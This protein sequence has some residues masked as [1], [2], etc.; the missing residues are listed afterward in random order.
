MSHHIE[1]HVSGSKSNRAGALGWRGAALL[2]LL[3]SGAAC[4][5]SAEVPD[6]AD[7][8]GQAASTGMYYGAYYNEYSSSSTVDPGVIAKSATYSNLIWLPL[9]GG[10]LTN[11]QLAPDRVTRCR[12]Q[13]AAVFNA[14]ASAGVSYIVEAGTG[15]WNSDY[16]ASVADAKARLRITRDNMPAGMAQRVAAVAI[17]DEPSLH[18]SY[19][20][21]RDKLSAFNRYVHELLPGAAAFLNFSTMEIARGLPALPDQTDWV[22][23]D[24]YSWTTGAVCRDINTVRTNLNKVKAYGGVKFVLIP[25]AHLATNRE[26]LSAEAVVGLLNDYKSLAL[27]EP[28]VVALM[29]YA[30]I[31]GGG[32]RGFANGAAD[33]NLIRT[34]V[35]NVGNRITGK[36][37]DCTR[38]GRL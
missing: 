11:G 18:A 10:R 8:T 2:A 9:C 25:Q 36:S 38:Q 12:D 28:R 14:S 7:E 24:C 26:P 5:A 6:D 22:G 33:T 32:Y 19:G 20:P 16:S 27:S 3:V 1:S 30:R 29:P 31:D 4:S 23:F 15:A 17:A 34:K 37:A 21:L 35:C 13:L